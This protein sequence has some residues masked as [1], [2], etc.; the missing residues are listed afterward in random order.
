MNK[1]AQ[2]VSECRFRKEIQGKRNKEQFE[3]EWPMKREPKSNVMSS[4]KSQVTKV[5]QEGGS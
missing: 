2:E 1:V 5:Y 3:K 4:V